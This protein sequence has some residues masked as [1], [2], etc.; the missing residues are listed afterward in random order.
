MDIP[1]S[2]LT[3]WV[4]TCIHMNHLGTL[5]QSELKNGNFERATDLSERARKR[6]WDLVNELFAAGASKPEGYA[7]PDKSA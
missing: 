7:E 4:D 6:A 2:T 1:E 3:R 5:I